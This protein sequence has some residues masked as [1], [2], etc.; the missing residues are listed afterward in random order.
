MIQAVRLNLIFKITKSNHHDC[1]LL[2]RNRNDR[3]SKKN[4]TRS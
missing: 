2:G 3:F 1:N 4:N